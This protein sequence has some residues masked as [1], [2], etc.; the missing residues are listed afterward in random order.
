MNMEREQFEREAV[1]ATNTNTSYVKD[2]PVICYY[3][4]SCLVLMNDWQDADYFTGSFLTLFPL[5]IGGHI[6]APQK[7]K[8]SL[9]LKA[10][11]K[12]SLNHHSRRYVLLFLNFLV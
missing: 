6:L 12:W 5:G 8:V 3:S 11:V 9:L 7:H 1:I 2:I 4:N 10:W